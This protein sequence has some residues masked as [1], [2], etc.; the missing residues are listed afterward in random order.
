MKKMLLLL[1]IINTSSYAHIYKIPKKN[2]RLIGEINKILIPHNNILSLEFFANKYQ[3]GLTN[4]IEANPEVDIFLPKSDS[5]LIIPNKIL[6]PNIIK[7][8]I[9]INSAEMLLYYFPEKENNVVIL[10][11]GIG[12][13]NHPTP[14]S[15][16]TKIYRKKKIHIGCLIIQY[17][18]N[19]F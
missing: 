19:I 2:D 3:T 1:I 11:V 4:L 18:K 5:T 14:I 6:I 13:I 7:E 16:T 9:I 8:G 17:V 15:W 12:E 10:P